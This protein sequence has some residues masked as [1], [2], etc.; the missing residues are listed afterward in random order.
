MQRQS[1]YFDDRLCQLIMIRNITKLL[2]YKDINAHNTKM[3]IYAQ[4]VSNEMLNP[5]K[6]I[7]EFTSQ[8]RTRLEEGSFNS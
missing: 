3:R 7:L 6:C 8:L 4:S 5:I 2:L 1:I